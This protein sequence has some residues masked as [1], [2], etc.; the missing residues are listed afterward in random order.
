MKYEECLPI[1]FK[2]SIVVKVEFETGEV[3]L[4]VLDKVF[5]DN[6]DGIINIVKVHNPHTRFK[7]TQIDVGD[8]VVSKILSSMSGDGRSITSSMNVTIKEGDFE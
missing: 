2:E 7:I 1:R 5:A 8:F 3:H 4:L 6:V